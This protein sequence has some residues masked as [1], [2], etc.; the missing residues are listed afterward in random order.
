M[1][2][3]GNMKRVFERFCRGLKE[4]RVHHGFTDIMGF[5]LLLLFYFARM[6]VLPALP[7]PHMHAVPLVARRG[8]QIP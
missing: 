1:E 7:V 4:V 8:R 2:K 5:K 3:G 6:S